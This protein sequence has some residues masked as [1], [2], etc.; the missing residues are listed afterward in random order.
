[1][2]GL[3]RF[4]MFVVV[5]GLAATISFMLLRVAPHDAIDAQLALSG[6]SQADIAQMRADMG[7]DA[8]LFEQYLRYMIGLLK[9][10]MG[11][12]FLNTLPVL[13]VIA[14]RLM[15]TAV[16]AVLTL[17]IASIL[18]VGLG[19]MMIWDNAFSVIARF[20]VS[21]SLSLPIYWT[22]TLAIIIFS[23]WLKIFPASGTQGIERLI[24]PVGV[25][26]FHILAPIARVTYAS[27][28]QIK[29]QP[30]VMVAH[31]KGLPEHLILW[32]YIVRV[33]LA[34]ILSVI[35][36]QTG[37]LLSGT[38][39]T[40]GLFVRSGVGQLLLTSV[41]ERDYPVVQG[42]VI[43]SAVFYMTAI[44]IGDWLIY[45]LDPRVNGSS[46]AHD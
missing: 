17:L 26:S 14:S 8:P 28:Y 29:S 34:P 15:P 25:L 31:A 44:M 41:I 4:M 2:M 24:L 10:D 6:A 32:R 12:S 5:I 27:L 19:I 38:V 30:F 20:I 23:G 18:G 7:L 43:F 36:L 1:M 42:I 13:D 9:G 35:T 37:F 33:G 3:K 21:L 39:I 11:Y 46:V 16:L 22:G 45:W 40:E